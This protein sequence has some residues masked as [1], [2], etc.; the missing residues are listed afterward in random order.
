MAACE[1]YND[2]VTN[3][4]TGIQ[5]SAI[6]ENRA[7]CRVLPASLRI[8]GAFMLADARHS[9]ERLWIRH[10]LAGAPGGDEY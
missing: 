5:P 3:A 10:G 8:G 6:A 2:A 7:D 4:L 1:L 9:V